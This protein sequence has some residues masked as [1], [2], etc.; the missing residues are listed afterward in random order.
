MAMMKYLCEMADDLEEIKS[1]VS[2]LPSSE[3]EI[4][5]AK[6]ANLENFFQDFKGRIE[7]V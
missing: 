7:D 3:V 1:V 4:F 2:Y 5:L 6:L